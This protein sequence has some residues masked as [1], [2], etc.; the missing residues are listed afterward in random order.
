MKKRSPAVILG[1]MLDSIVAIKQYTAGLTEDEFRQPGI[2]QDAIVRRLE[3]IGEAA[4]QLGETLRAQFPEVAW[5]DILGMRNRI[6]HGYHKL[7][8]S[9]VWNTIQ[10]DLPVLEQ[11][12]RDIL[13]RLPPEQ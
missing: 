3:I 10:Q 2:V 5:P 4:Y 11:Q 8:L 13:Q 1:D 12:L 6:V 7:A 9:I